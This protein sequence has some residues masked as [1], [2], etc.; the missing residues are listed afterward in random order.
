MRLLYRMVMKMK[1]GLVLEG[2]GMRGLYTVGALDAFL[3]NEIFFDY[4]IGVSAG[5][6]NA[7][8]YISHQRG[9]GLRVDTQYVT[10]KRYIGLDPILHKHSV[11]G[12]DFIYDTIPQEL[13]PF[14]YDAFYADRSEFVTVVTDAET[15]E[16]VYLGKEK[17]VGKDFTPLKASA[18]I[19]MFSP[20]VEFEGKLY[21]D[22][23]AADSI[24]VEKALKDGCDRLVIILTRPRGYVKAPERIRSVYTRVLKDYPKVI[25][26]L[27]RR[28]AVYNESLARCYELEKAGKAVVL[29]PEYALP[30]DKFGTDKEKLEHCYYEGERDCKHN[31]ARIRSLLSD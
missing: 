7:V 16:A 4:I 31:L 29:V 26:T 10:D 3:D 21:F 18:A 20:P 11:F 19:P 13:D 24:P 12:L 1:T 8:S 25:E 17:L 23:G 5:A 15:G 22:G 30:V 6:G 14:D 28:H 9:R 2:G 27:D